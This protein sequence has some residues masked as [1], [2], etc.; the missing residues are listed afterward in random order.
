MKING[1]EIRPGNV[2][3]HKDALWRAV[4]IQAVKPGKGGAFNQVELKD[5]RTGTKLNERFRATETVERVT[6]EQKDYQF[7]FGDDDLLT[8]MDTETYEQIEASKTMLLDEQAPFLVDGITVT[9]ETFEGEVLGITLPTNM[10]FEIAEADAVVKG[11]TQ[12]SSY[13]PAV[14]DN[15]V[16]ILVPPHIEAGTRVVVNTMENTYVERAKD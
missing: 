8:F 6:L 15:G 12:S 2:I 16:K 4:K 14:L 1:N 3:S 10:T 9:I 7:L 5:I 11:Q 13:K